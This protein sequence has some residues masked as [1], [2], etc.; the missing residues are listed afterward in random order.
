MSCS[1]QSPKPGS[2]DPSSASTTLS[3]PAS[4]SRR[5]RPPAPGRGCR[6]PR[7]ARAASPRPRRAAA[8]RPR[9]P[10]RSAP[11]RTRSARCSGR[12]RSGRRAPRDTRPAR[13]VASSGEP[14]SVTITNRRAISPG[15]RP[16]SAKACSYTRRWL[17]VSTV[18][19]DLLETTTSVRSSRSASARSTGCGSVVSSTVSGT[20][21]PADHLG[22]QRRAAH[23]AQHDVVEPLLT[24]V[25]G[26]HGQRAEQR[27]GRPRRVQPAQPD[28]RLPA[29]SG[30]HS[31]GSLAA[32]ADGRPSAASLSAAGPA[33]ARTA[34]LRQA[35]DTPAGLPARR[36]P[37]FTGLRHWR[38][39]SA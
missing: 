33:T 18:E 28:R 8:R 13:A 34:A 23:P 19:P 38:S 16:R 9:R 6:R 36:A 15:A 25:A 11:G 32:S 12:P 29:A 17:S 2:P 5:A 24:C 37:H 10:A 1:A 20:R 39:S 27:P 31:P 3:W 21:G 35:T 22:G 26:E 14:G 7:P 4:A 30:P